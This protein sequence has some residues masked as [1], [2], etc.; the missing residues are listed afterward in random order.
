MA[1]H[2]AITI[3]GIEQPL[4]V[5]NV[6]TRTPEGREVQVR[7]DLVPSAPLDVFQVD[8]GLMAQFPQCLG[9]SCAGTVVATGADVQRLAVHDRV[10]GFFFHNEFEK[11]QQ[12]YVTASEHLFGKVPDG[13]PLEAAVTMPT[14]FCTSFYTLSDKLGLELPWP[15]PESFVPKHADVPILVWGAGTSV[16]HFALQ[17]LKHWGYTN[18]L[19]TASP[20]HHEK[21]RA[22]GARRVFDYRDPNVTDSIIDFVGGHDAANGLRVFDTVD[23]KSSSLLPISKIATQPGSIVAAV[24]PVVISPTSDPAGVQVSLDVAKKA[25]WAPG[26]EVHGIVSYAYEANAFLRDHLQPD[27]MPTLLAQGAIEPNKARVIE[28]KYLLERAST[29]I[30]IMKSGTVSGERLV[31]RVWTPEEFPE[32]Q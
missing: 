9:D 27:I 10:F 29:A 6:P 26:V 19:A 21:L 22:Y 20:K 14:N 28:G 11:G 5:T 2:P 16:G 17:I 23:S 4:T 7:V 12:V 31:W 30:N 25:D 24:L 3:T 32:F 15:K 8:A 1:T 13:V 18:V